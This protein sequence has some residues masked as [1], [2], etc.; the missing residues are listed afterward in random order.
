[1]ARRKPTPKTPPPTAEPRPAPSPQVSRFRIL[2]LGFLIGA[3]WGV[4]IALI[5]LALGRFEA[6]DIGGWIFRIVTAALLG[7]VIATIVGPVRTA[8]AEGTLAPRRKLFRRGR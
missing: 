5:M 6:D 2:L 3:A 4:A 7:M 8:R 1:M